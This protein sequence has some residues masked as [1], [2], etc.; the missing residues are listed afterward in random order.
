LWKGANGERQ[1]AWR[2]GKNREFLFRGKIFNKGGRKDAG[3][4]DGQGVKEES[5]IL[6][7]GLGIRTIGGGRVSDQSMADGRVTSRKELKVSRGPRR[8]GECVEGQTELPRWELLTDGGND[9]IKAREGRRVDGSI[10][11]GGGEN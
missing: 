5:V 3:S 10:S 6:D 9:K 11:G 7:S 2:L 8:G 1:K 4:G